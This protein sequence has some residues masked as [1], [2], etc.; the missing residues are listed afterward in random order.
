MQQDG[1][2]SAQDWWAPVDR[3]DFGLHQSR[4]M[5]VIDSKGLGRVTFGGAKELI[6]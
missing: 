5:N 6:G 4:I 2:R 1:L 3:D